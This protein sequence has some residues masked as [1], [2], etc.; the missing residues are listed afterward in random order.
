MR[1]RTR[2]HDFELPI[3]KYEFNKQNF[4]VQLLFNYVR[5]CVLLY[6]LHFVFY[7]IK[8]L[9]TYLL[10][11]VSHSLTVYML[12]CLFVCVSSVFGQHCLLVVYVFIVLFMAAVCNR[13]GHYICALWFL[14][15]SIYLFFL[16]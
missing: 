15:L 16:A 12:H 5:F 7:C 14:L 3:V 10:F 1:L 11:F 13:A 8:F 6:Y 2:G 9:L 4:I